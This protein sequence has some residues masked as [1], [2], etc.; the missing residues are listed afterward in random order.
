MSKSVIPHI[1]IVEEQDSILGYFSE[2]LKRQGFQ[3]KKAT[4]LDEIEEILFNYN[5]FASLVSMELETLDPTEIIYEVTDLNPAGIVLTFAS[6]ASAK[7]TTESLEAGAK[8]YFLYPV[9]DWKRLR[10]I[11][12]Q[13]Q[14]LWAE[15]LEL[16]ELRKSVMKLRAFRSN[17]L[18]DDI[19]GS[20]PAIQELFSQI[21]ALASLD[22]TTLIFGESGVGKELVASAIHQQ[23]E[24]SEGIFVAVN[25]AAISPALFESELFGHRKGSFTGANQHRDGF[26]ALAAGGTLFLDEIGELPIQ[27]QPKLLRLLEQWEYRPV[28]SDRLEKFT[29]RVIAATNV[30]LDVAV[31][32]GAFREDLYFRLSV[33]E[34]YVPPLRQ[35]MGDIKL[36]S[37]Y[38]LERYNREYGRAIH[39]I[40]PR[41]LALLEE[42]DWRRN[43]VRELER[44]IQRGMVRTPKGES[45]LRAETLFWH[46]GRQILP[47]ERMWM[48]K[49]K[50]ERGDEL[51]LEL[52][53]SEAMGYQRRKALKK[54]LEYHLIKA[55][56]KK[57]LAAMSCG[58]Q[59]ANFSRLLREIGD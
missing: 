45:I 3:V 30:D 29:G 59:P 25:C 46:H 16:Q 53:Y 4:S 15:Q 57:S 41:A 51:W 49:K 17:R 14:Q 52:P 58:I 7:M 22:V 21:E 47:S 18:F 26:C 28:G 40:H 36:L 19:K 20:S 55:K 24:R 37:Y 39:R 2:N 34:V 9:Q 12:R 11:L 43:N 50:S 33:Q 32:E 5:I 10:H 27:L 44:E 13:S 48:T 54:Y 42:Y 23:S 6:E 56:G 1:L 35:R 31:Q 8:D 38:F